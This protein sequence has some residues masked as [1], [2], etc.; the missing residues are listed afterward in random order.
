MGG[1]EIRAQELK[2]PPMK[3]K[4]SRNYI[5]WTRWTISKCQKFFAALEA[6][7]PLKNA[8][9]LSGLPYAAVIGYLKRGEADA[10]DWYLEIAEAPTL[11]GQF[12]IDTQESIAKYVESEIAK[13]ENRDWK[14][15]MEH[16]KRFDP[17]AWQIVNSSARNIT[18]VLVRQDNSGGEKADIVTVAR[19]TEARLISAPK[20]GVQYREHVL[21][22]QDW[23]HRQL[24][25]V[26]DV[27]S[28]DPVE[29]A[30]EAEV[31]SVPLAGPGNGRA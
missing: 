22:D 15:L 31:L 8:A 24:P 21:D 14:D 2:A 20:T 27:E 1:G 11:A 29:G 5:R 18:N 28:S 3:M 30:L 4:G 13:H 7:L 17:D 19:G 12:Y 9:G 25:A 23:K 10:T 26:I 6:G 16:F